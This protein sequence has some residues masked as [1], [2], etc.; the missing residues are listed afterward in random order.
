MRKRLNFF[1]GTYA[2][3]VE[4]LQ[5]AY[6][7]SRFSRDASLCLIVARR[8][9]A[10]VITYQLLQPILNISSKT[11]RGDGENGHGMGYMAGLVTS[12]VT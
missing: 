8:H 6:N 9:Y 2:R 12:S 4:L 3:S 10:T 5:S 7:E 11:P 1:Y